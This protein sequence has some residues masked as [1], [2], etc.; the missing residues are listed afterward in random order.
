[1]NTNSVEPKIRIIPFSKSNQGFDL[2]GSSGGAAYYKKLE[3]FQISR[4]QN[5]Y[6][7]AIETETEPSSEEPELT[8]REIETKLLSM[9]K[10]K[11]DQSTMTVEDLLFLLKL[12]KRDIDEIIPL[13]SII[14]IEI[15]HNDEMQKLQIALFANPNTRFLKQIQELNFKNL[16]INNETSRIISLLLT[17]IIQNSHILS[18]LKNL[19]FG[20]IQ[21]STAF[22]LPEG[23]NNILHC[24]IGNIRHQATFTLPQSY[25]NLLSL[26]IGNVQGKVI[27]PDTLNNLKYFTFGRIDSSATRKFLSSYK[28]RLDLSK[29]N[30]PTSYTRHIEHA[31]TDLK[32]PLVRIISKEDEHSESNFAMVVKSP[33]MPRVY[34][35]EEKEEGIKKIEKHESHEASPKHLLRIDE[36]PVEDPE[37]DTN[38]RKIFLPIRQMLESKKT[39]LSMYSVATGED[40]PKLS[41]RNTNAGTSLSK[42]FFDTQVDTDGDTSI[43]PH[44]SLI[45]FRRKSAPFRLQEAI[46]SDRQRKKKFFEFLESINRKHSDTTKDSADKS[47]NKRRVLSGLSQSNPNIAISITSRKGKISESSAVFLSHSLQELANSSMYLED[48]SKDSNDY[49]PFETFFDYRRI[50]TLEPPLAKPFWLSDNKSEDS[51]FKAIDRLRRR[52]TFDSQRENLDGGKCKKDPIIVSV[53]EFCDVEALSKSGKAENSFIKLKF[54]HKDD[55]AKFQRILITEEKIKGLNQIKKIILPDINSDLIDSTNKLLITIGQNLNCFTQLTELHIKNI[56]QRVIFTLPEE[57]NQLS[58]FSVG[59]I[60]YDAS[61]IIPPIS[62]QGLKKLLFGNIHG[63]VTLPPSFH[64]LKKL[65]YGRVDSHSLLKQLKSLKENMDGL[66]DPN[67]QSLSN[68]VSHERIVNMNTPYVSINPSRSQITQLSKTKMSNRS[69]LTPSGKNLLFT[70]FDSTNVVFENI[71]QIRDLQRILEAKP[72]TKQFDK[73]KELNFKNI[74]INDET[75]VVINSLLKSIFENQK[76]EFSPLCITFGDVDSDVAFDLPDVFSNLEQL[77]VGNLLLN[78]TL[79]LP[80]SLCRLKKLSFGNIYR[81][82]KIEFPSS[83]NDLLDLSIGTMM[84]SSTFIEL[85]NSLTNLRNLTLGDFYPNTHVDLPNTLLNLDNLTIGDM[86]YNIEI[87]IPT[88]H[89]K[90]R[91]LTLGNVG[92][93]ITFTFPKFLKEFLEITFKENIGGEIFFNLP[94]SLSPPKLNNIDLNLTLLSSNETFNKYFLKSQEEDSEYSSSD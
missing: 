85:P 26:S 80:D 35:V 92:N 71:N 47:L 84:N 29:E 82:A 36:N 5:L 63:S 28:S 51:S 19:T 21:Q 7:R 79:K 73:I 40:T 37:E 25:K 74:K 56:Q 88:T 48:T 9:Q 41:R 67:L 66:D 17:N 70:L 86:A 89:H 58:C 32:N 43:T 64:N 20:N 3:Y 49:S 38:L 18:Q 59:N 50:K 60:G 62:F 83:L 14:T 6:E 94:S 65:T 16:D 45:T 75:S 39:S 46:V 77:H 34:L 30:A 90:F 54:N 53:K 1:M 42:I 72:N 11:K 87:N 68:F 27:L 13:N 24:S 12:N 23:L 69:R 78:A 57:L 31:T 4:Q 22:T 93:D 76:P 15:N 2:D 10:Y 33:Q 55:F 61:L 8:R 52:T 44:Q 81:E 91:A